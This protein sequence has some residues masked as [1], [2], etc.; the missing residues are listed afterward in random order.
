MDAVG[1]GGVVELHQHDLPLLAGVGQLLLGPRPLRGALVEVGQVGVGRGGAGEHLGERAVVV[2]AGELAL[3][4]RGEVLLGQVR[5]V[6]GEHRP[7]QGA[8][9]RVLV[10][11][12][13]G[14]VQGQHRDGTVVG[15]VVGAPVL[16]V[17][18]V[19]ALT[20][21]L[22][23]LVVLVAADHGR[24]LV[25]GGAVAAVQRG[26]GLPVAQ[27]GQQRRGG[28]QRAVLTGK[29][30]PELVPGRLVARALGEV[31]GDHHQVRV[32]GLDVLHVLLHGGVLAQRVAQGELPVAGG[33]AEDP[34]PGR[35]LTGTGQGVLGVAVHGGQ[36]PLAVLHPAVGL[37]LGVGERDDADLVP[38]VGRRRGLEAG[39]VGLPAL[40][41]RVP[42]GLARLQ[43]GDGH[44]VPV[45]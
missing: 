43:P 38:G 16:R 12:P 2:L 34:V 8:G 7:G 24:G 40:R 23:V 25:L 6:P 37:G 32:G 3:G 28:G 39:G 31:T 26:V 9:L 21:P 13:V 17:L 19:G 14:G 22:E 42:V 20:G 11:D 44:P 30:A 45:V 18:L 29:V 33:V 15:A 1:V 36:L 5:V 10:R 35:A 4:V 41:D 27:R